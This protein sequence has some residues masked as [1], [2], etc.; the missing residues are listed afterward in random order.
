MRNVFTKKNHNVYIAVEAK[1]VCAAAV[2]RVRAPTPRR[3]RR[4]CFAPLPPLMHRNGMRT[5]DEESAS[6]C[7]ERGGEGGALAAAADF[8]P[9]DRPTDRPIDSSD[10]MAA[11]LLDAVAHSRL[12]FPRLSACC[13]SLVRSSGRCVSLRRPPGEAFFPGATQRSRPQFSPALLFL[14]I[15]KRNVPSAVGFL[16]FI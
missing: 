8:P 13:I 11:D 2:F 14:L 10:K 9:T 16:L 12:R 1:L 15:L 5:S 4:R 3:R 6:E 7:A